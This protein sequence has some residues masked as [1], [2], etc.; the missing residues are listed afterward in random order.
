MGFRKHL[1]HRRHTH[2]HKHIERNKKPFLSFRRLKRRIVS[3]V[4]F[5]NANGISKYGHREWYETPTRVV[6]KLHYMQHHAA[7]MHVVKGEAHG[8]GRG[9]AYLV[10][11][12]Q[13]VCRMD[14]GGWTSTFRRE[15][16]SC[17]SYYSETFT[18]SIGWNSVVFRP[19]K[20]LGYAGSCTLNEAYILRRN[21]LRDL[22]SSSDL[23]REIP[24]NFIAAWF[25]EWLQLR[26]ETNEGRRSIFTKIELLGQQNDFPAFVRRL[27]KMNASRF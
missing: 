12:V 3:R 19:M 25:P 11:I 27:T 24:G 2:T 5:G 7:T 4:T 6:K 9:V 10:H 26:D 23:R 13:S 21:S 22:I 20:R 16:L 18:D 15:G 1:I 8:R 14:A 17:L